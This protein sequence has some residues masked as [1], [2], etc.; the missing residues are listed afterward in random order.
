MILYLADGLLFTSALTGTVT[1]YWL[2][3]IGIALQ[4]SAAVPALRATRSLR[5]LVCCPWRA[6]V[7]QARTVMSGPTVQTQYGSDPKFGRRWHSL[8]VK[9]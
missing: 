4:W 5:A 3:A 8:S 2:C 9:C 1:G 7:P 6:T